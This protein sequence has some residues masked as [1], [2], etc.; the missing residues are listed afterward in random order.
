[1]LMFLLE[2]HTVYTLATMLEDNYLQNGKPLLEFIKDEW[3][4]LSLFG[5]F[6]ASV[7]NHLD[8]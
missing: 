8:K 4:I 2:A 7:V 1:M 3:R 5:R 6:K